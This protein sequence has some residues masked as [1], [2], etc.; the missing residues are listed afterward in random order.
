MKAC[1]ANLS[2]VFTFFEDEG[3][4][5]SNFL[6][7]VS[8]GDPGA[9]TTPDIDFTD[10]YG[11]FGLL[12]TNIISSIFIMIGLKR[13]DISPQNIE[14]KGNLPIDINYIIMFINTLQIMLI[15]SFLIF[16]RYSECFWNVNVIFFFF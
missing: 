14:N 6:N 9:G 1:N 7:E 4:K 2:Q 8:E 13:Y 3:G 10:I 12:I 16:L 11:A 5:I 15:S